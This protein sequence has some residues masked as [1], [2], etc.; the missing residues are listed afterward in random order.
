MTNMKR[1]T[2]KVSAITGRGMRVSSVSASS[3]LIDSDTLVGFEAEVENYACLMRIEGNHGWSNKPDGSLRSGIEFVFDAPRKGLQV[4]QSIAYITS[5]DVLAHVSSPRAGTH[6]HIDWLDVEESESLYRLAVIAAVIEPGI[7]AYAGPDRINNTFLVPLAKN[8]LRVLAEAL[9]DNDEGS[10]QNWAA[11]GSRYRGTN[12]T[13]L[14]RFGS[15]EFR[16]FPAIT[17][18]VEVMTWINLCLMLKRAAVTRTADFSAMELAEALSNPTFV[19][20]FIANNFAEFGIGEILLANIDLSSAAKVAR[21]LSVA[22][23]TDRPT[24]PT[25]WGRSAA[26]KRFIENERNPQGATNV[27][28]EAL[29]DVLSDL[30]MIVEETS[31]VSRNPG[32]GYLPVVDNST[33]DTTV[34]LYQPITPTQR[35]TR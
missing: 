18:Y 30:Y 33:S 17:S 1:R 16:Y 7:Y 13:A 21:I 4:E 24:I 22:G 12:F 9:G 28:T 32:L 23:R 2:G 6:I 20:D 25:S 34:F 5:K 8:D 15:V 10:F 3:D 29:D 14:R 11:N 19:R 26:A 27:P 35:G 31:S